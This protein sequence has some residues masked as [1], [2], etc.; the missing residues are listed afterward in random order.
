MVVVDNLVAAYHDRG[1][2][3]RSDSDDSRQSLTNYRVGPV[4]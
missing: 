4:T 1:E 2:Q 3:I